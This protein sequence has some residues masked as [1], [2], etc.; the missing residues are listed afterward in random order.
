MHCRTTSC[1]STSLRPTSSTSPFPRTSPRST[2]TTTNTTKTKTKTK[3][4]PAQTQTRPST[5]RTRARGSTRRRR[6]TPLAA[7]LR[8]PARDWGAG[9]AGHATTNTNAR[10]ASD[11]GS[12]T[13]TGSSGGTTSDGESVPPSP[14]YASP[15]FALGRAE[16][17]LGAPTFQT[18]LHPCRSAGP[19]AA[20]L[21]VYV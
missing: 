1:T 3:T 13:G 10:P 7:V 16:Y 19:D 6:G 5:R 12:G 14:E 8:G 17:D 21:F 18:V 15:G 11:D 9:G 4:T 20:P 2:S